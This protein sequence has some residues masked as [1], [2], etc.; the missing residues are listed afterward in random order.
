[1]R[2]PSESNF[3]AEGSRSL[4]H[5]SCAALMML[6]LAG[7]GGGGDGPSAPAPA[8]AQAQVL[9]VS[10]PSFAISG[11]DALVELVSP[12]APLRSLLIKVNGRD[13]TQD[14]SVDSRT[15]RIVGLVDGL[16]LGKNTLTVEGK[17][18]GAVTPASLELTNHPTT[19]EIFSAH[20][21]PWVKL[22]PFHGHLTVMER[23]VRDAQ[24]KAAISGGVSSTNH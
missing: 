10:S 5:A 9:S 13:V 8:P 23:G 17:V 2:M 21:R 24:I 11:G 19:G 6:V 18:S 16:N 4:A 12:T 1:M 22:T 3:T 7:C 15:G 20:Q 14:F